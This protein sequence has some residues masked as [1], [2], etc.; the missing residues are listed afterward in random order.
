MS[1]A[2]VEQLIFTPA[3]VVRRSL[4]ILAGALVVALSA[5]VA[6]PLPLTPVPVTLQV[7]AVLV[8]GGLLGP[9]AGAASMV[10]Y[11]AL[12]I[13]GLPVFAPG[14][15]PG[16]ARLLGPTGGY[17]LAYPVAA[18][19]AGQASRSGGSWLRLVLGLLLATA[20]IHLGGVAQLAVL[21]RDPAWAVRAG[22]LPFLPFDLVKLVA[23]GLILRRLGPT[24]R[25]RL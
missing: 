9:K 2:N 23:A 21:S 6:I 13:A 16:V 19:V 11:L 17:L 14:G 22:S 3:A 15:A 25:A 8:V 10:L 7:L 20:A 4:V 1:Q 18:A 12:G 24:F 5:Q